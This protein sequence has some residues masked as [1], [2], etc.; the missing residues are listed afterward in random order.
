MAAFVLL[1]VMP[2]VTVA[3]DVRARFTVSAYVA[4]HVTLKTVSQPAELSVSGE[5]I[6]RG[7]LDVA[8]VYRVQNNDPAGYMIRLAPRVGLASAIEVS[9]LASNVMVRDEVVEVL[10]PA[11]LR[12][13]ELELRF[14]LLLD[15]D[16]QP[17]TYAVPVY[18]AA[19]SL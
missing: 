14:R 16:A 6:S 18:V 10:Q 19:T 3:G 5:D 9:G 8:A 4:P 11:A 7:Y 1:A 15:A 13:Q 2:Q 17:G 12:A